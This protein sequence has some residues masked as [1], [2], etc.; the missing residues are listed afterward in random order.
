MK[1]ISFICDWAQIQETYTG[2]KN[3]M[4]E[5]SKSEIAIFDSYNFV[6]K[7]IMFCVCKLEII[8]SRLIVSLQ[9]H[10]R[11]IFTQNK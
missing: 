2:N 9:S 5:H 7:R 4:L 11:F 10:I 8:I 6:T 3:V 1:I